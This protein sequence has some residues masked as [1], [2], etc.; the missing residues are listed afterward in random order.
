M[1]G[2]VRRFADTEGSQSDG[3]ATKSHPMATKTRIARYQR[4]LPVS[5]SPMN[6]TKPPAATVTNS[7]A[8]R[9]PV[10]GD[11]DGGNMASALA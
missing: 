2:R 6:P 5:L 7:S 9:A 1:P 11:R 3:W 4:S 10:A 8:S